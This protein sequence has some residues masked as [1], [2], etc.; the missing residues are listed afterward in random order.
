MP[1]YN[2]IKIVDNNNTADFMI[3]V[4]SMPNWKS[5]ISAVR[6]QCIRNLDYD[7]VWKRDI[8]KYFYLHY[9]VSCV[10]KMEFADLA[11]ARAHKQV[12]Y[13]EIHSK[14]GRLHSIITFL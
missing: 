2:F 14:A 1:L 4:S 5:R 12:I 11:S 9:S 10:E 6:T 13:K 7:V 3:D 8:Y